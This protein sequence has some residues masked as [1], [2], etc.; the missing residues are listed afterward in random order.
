MQNINFKHMIHRKS[1][2][3]GAQVCIDGPVGPYGSPVDNPF[4]ETNQYMNADFDLGSLLTAAVTTAGSAYTA[5]QQSEAAKANLQAQ[6]TALQAQQ[7]AILAS[8]K[9]AAAPIVTTAGMPKWAIWTIVSVLGIGG[10]IT[11]IILLKRK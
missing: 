2:T 1:H 5:S 7:A 10:L 6:Q 3:H 11:T 9:T 8:Q 4:P